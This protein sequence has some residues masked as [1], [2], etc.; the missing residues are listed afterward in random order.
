M[1]AQ[2]TAFDVLVAVLVVCF[3]SAV[4]GWAGGVGGRLLHSWRITRL[5]QAVLKLT[6]SSRGSAGQAQTQITRVRKASADEEAEQLRVA[7]LKGGL[8]GSAQ[9]LP[10]T[11]AEW[12]ARA[13]AVGATRVA[14]AD[15]VPPK[16][17]AVPK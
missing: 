7:L 16:P 4:F 13:R 11:D 9:V 2:L 15:Y 14:D 6:M 8:R 5:E 1:L 12:M 17:I 3:L 10:C